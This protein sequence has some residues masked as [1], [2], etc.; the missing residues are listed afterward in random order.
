M[1]I[2]M[3]CSALLA[4]VP[5]KTVWMNEDNQHFYDGN[6]HGDE[7]MT[8]EG[9]RRLVDTYART[10]FAECAKRPFSL[11]RER[12][13]SLFGGKREMGGFNRSHA[14]TT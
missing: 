12:P 3:L 9:C 7:D 8:V 4:A 2:L 1:T 14:G 5:A 6:F 13:V 10:G 11:D